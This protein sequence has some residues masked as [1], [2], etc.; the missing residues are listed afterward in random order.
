MRTWPRLIC[1]RLIP[2]SNA[3]ML[4]PASP[5]VKE[6]NNYSSHSGGVSTYTIKFLVEHLCRIHISIYAYAMIRNR[7]CVPIPVKMVFI[8][9]PRPIIS[10]SS[11]LCTI[12]R[13]TRPVATVP[14][15]AMEN[16]S[17]NA[18]SKN[19][20]EVVQ[21]GAHLQWEARTASGGHLQHN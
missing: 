12:P 2:R 10:T 16:T 7:V 13:S 20:C 8:F 3:P 6:L 4:S 5:F 14:R 11:P 17:D 19:F 9:E 18:V 15:P 21:S 1:S